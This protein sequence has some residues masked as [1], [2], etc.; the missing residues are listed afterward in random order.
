MH[1]HFA[2][3]L[4]LVFWYVGLLSEGFAFRL[5]PAAPS[6]SVS[7]PEVAEVGFLNHESHFARGAFLDKVCRRIVVVPAPPSRASFCLHGFPLRL[8][9]L[10]VFVGQDRVAVFP[11]IERFFVVVEEFLSFSVQSAVLEITVRSPRVVVAPG[12]W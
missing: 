11:G 9:S 8:W 4:S 5:E 7:P 2:Q 12:S 3:A 10:C 6:P 1:S